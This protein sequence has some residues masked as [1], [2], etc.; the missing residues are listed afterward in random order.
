LASG[1]EAAAVGQICRRLDGIPLAIELAAARVRVLT[2][3]QIAAR[4][5]DRFNL[6]TRG[7]RGVLPR[8]QTLRALIDWSYDSLPE[9]EAALLRRLSVF[10]GG[11]TLEAAEAVADCGLRIADCPAGSKTGSPSSEPLTLSPIR[12]PESA[13]R[14]AEVLDLLDALVDR[15]LVLVDEVA[16]R[17]RYRMLETVRE[18]AREKL[19]GSG[20]LAAVRN[21]HRDWCL[22]LVAQVEADSPEPERT[23][24]LTRLEPDLDNVRAALAWC[25]EAAEESSDSDAAEAGLCLANALD[26]LWMRFGYPMEDSSSI[27]RALVRDSAASAPLRAR[28]FL[29]AAQLARSRGRSESAM[30]YL[31]SAQQGYEE[32]L[33]LARSEGDR[34]GAANAVL[35]LAIVAY[36]VGDMEAAWSYGLE[37]RQ[38][39]AELG[40]RS[41]IVQSLAVLCDIAQ[42]RGDSGAVR[43]LLEERLAL[44]RELGAS[45]LLIHVLGGMGHRMRDEGDYARSRTLYQESLVLRRE[46]GDR[47]ALAQSL[48]DL[49]VLAGREGHAERAIRLL[50]AGEAFCETMG[51]RPPVA[52]VSE[53][54]RTVAEGR[55]ALGEAAFAAVWAE[56]R[57]M[58]LEQAVAYALGEN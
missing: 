3:Q 19:A 27:E 46:L 30:S 9:E 28:A 53:Y 38:R 51:A 39:R 13:I 20:E 24:R 26:W 50:G 23:A 7:A 43:T 44:A 25:N 21:Q 1:A 45:G 6:L 37:A 54:E 12:N 5:D 31:Q 57:A 42:A 8:H 10:T 41:G 35:A 58:S 52:V 56:G 2:P 4:L 49:A 14:N 18:Y 48:E 47:I 16:D 34:S 55:A 15:S 22:Q 36:E 17:L 40:D 29:R 33:T 32:V 11:W